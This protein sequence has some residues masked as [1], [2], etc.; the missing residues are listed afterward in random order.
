MDRQEYMALSAMDLQL[1]DRIYECAFAPEC[2]P[3]VLDELAK[4]ADARGGV[5]F[6]AKSKIDLRWTASAVLS[7][8]FKEYVVS[9]MLARCVR[10]TRWFAAVHPGFLVEFDTWTAEELDS[11]PI[12]RDFLRPRG[13]GWAAGT[14]ICLPTGD[15]LVLSIE[16]D[17]AR[18]PVEPAVVNR[19]NALRPHLIRSALMSARLHFERARAATEALGLIGLPALFIDGHAKIVAANHLIEKLTEHLRLKAH[20]RVLLKDI[21]ADQLL[22]ETVASL[23]DGTSASVRSFAVRDVDGAAAF[24]AHVIPLRRT[25]RDIISRG[26]AALV[27][28]PVTLP[29]APPVELV[30]S[31]F[32][33]TPAEARVARGLAAGGTAEE[34]ASKGGV[35]LNTIRTQVRGVLEKTGCRRQAEIVALLGGVSVLRS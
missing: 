24:V 28:S 12:Y 2:W 4:I 32:D 13:L 14:A 30:Q 15:S 22:Q 17:Y 21:R 29:Q 16:R 1:I 26:E 3:G 33:L 7:E 23:R 6:A 25:A 20:D 9:G 10:R 27:L 31:L 11:I 8:D 35:S 34:I 5:L 18:G 19:L